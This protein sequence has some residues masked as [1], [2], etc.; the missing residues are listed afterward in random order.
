MSK[1]LS[2][3]GCKARAPG[4]WF[5]AV[6]SLVV[7]SLS[8]PAKIAALQ[9]K[10]NEAASKVEGKVRSPS[11][12]LVADAAVTLTGERGEKG[13]E[14]KTNADGTFVLLPSGAGS[15]TLRVEKEGFD[16]AIVGSIRLG[17]GETKHVNVVIQHRQDTPSAPMHF[18]DEPT[19]TVA[20]VTDWSTAGLHGSDATARTSETLAREA[21]ALKAPPVPTSA[22]GRSEADSHR[23][24]GESK[25][26]S[27]D[28][29]GAVNEFETAAR[30]EPTEENYFAWGTELLLHRGN[31]AAVEVFRKGVKVHP[32][33]SRML[34]GLGAAYYADGQYGDAAEHVCAASDLNP[35]DPALYAFLGKMEEASAELFPCG[36]SRL[37]RFAQEQPGSAIANYYYGLVLWKRGRQSQNAAEI[38]EAEGYFK[39]AVVIDTGFGEV[40]L[41][42]GML[43]NARG[44]RDAAI[45]TFQKAIAAN[46]MLRD[47]HYQLSIL[48]RRTGEHAKAA[49]EL[50]TYNEI[51]R[52][53]DAERKKEQRELRQFVTILKNG[54]S[55]GPR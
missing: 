16:P 32:Q 28:P 2:G 21:A 27:G 52:T 23:L 5:C 54:Q 38:V 8:P 15:Y 40:Y 33:S 50:K 45:A 4:P 12:E 31:A 53:E 36:G 11:G 49:S 46:P 24:L 18:S 13:A 20:G 22:A 14:T 34:A 3:S 1:S 47:A 25:E 9:S 17:A 6:L 44:D 10:A 29:V 30:L 48:Y 43:Y 19:F 35:A 26:K 51:R 37:A 42:L 39:K 41:K 55:P 7:F